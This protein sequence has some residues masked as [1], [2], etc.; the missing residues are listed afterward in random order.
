[1][2][3]RELQS[4]ARWRFHRVTDK[5]HSLSRSPRDYGTG[6]LLKLPEIRII[7]AVGNRP[8]ISI[9]ELARELGVVKSNASTQ[10]ASLRRRQYVER[11]KDTTNRKTIS[12]KLTDKGQVAYDGDLRIHQDFMS[13]DG[14]ELTPGHYV[15]FN[16]VLVKLEEFLDA[17]LN[18][19]L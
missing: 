1:M 15:I 18:H 14:H 17:R 16:E 12:L 10:V 2:D 11:V 5:I 6:E 4:E 8:G 19:N 13:H 9:T 7:F 3:I